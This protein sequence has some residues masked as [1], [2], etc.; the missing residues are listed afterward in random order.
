MKCKSCDH[1]NDKERFFCSICGEFLGGNCPVCSTYNSIDDKFCGKC[2]APLTTKRLNLYSINGD[3]IKNDIPIKKT[4]EKETIKTTHLSDK[5]AIMDILNEVPEVR[6]PLSKSPPLYEKIIIPDEV[7]VFEVPEIK[8]AVN[9][10]EKNL[11]IEPVE[12]VHEVK[13]EDVEITTQDFVE[14]VKEISSKIEASGEI[15]LA[16][17]DSMNNR[18]QIL[19]KNGEAI[20]SMGQKGNGP[21]QF[22]N[23]QKIAYDRKNNWLYV[24]DFNN[25]RINKFTL[26]GAFVSSIGKAGNGDGEFSYPQGVA[27]DTSSN[28][29][30]VDAFNNRIQI[31]NPKGVFIR[32]FDGNS[33]IGFDTPSGISIL[34]DGS[35]FVL[36][37]SNNRLLK[38]DPNF[39]LIMEMKDFPNPTVGFDEPS[40]LTISPSGEIYICDTGND[41]IKFF[42]SE[43]NYIDTFGQTGKSE[44]SFDN[45]SDL[46]I[47]SNNTLYVADTWNNRIQLFSAAGEYLKTIGSFGSAPGKFNYVTDIKVLEL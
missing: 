44:G 5:S 46:H 47:D 30:V 24:S 4:S 26:E 28:L 38:F 13:I 3:K 17:V 8:P 43:G 6:T 34:D 29:Y 10:Q 22:E 33:N 14:P 39:N 7:D 37:T 20:R 27:V 18:V 1:N 23:P 36:D 21:G 2:G 12:E 31:F 16:V 41:M 40:G 11:E 35:I 25:C 19:D 42:D 15:I 45:P 9:V 32:K